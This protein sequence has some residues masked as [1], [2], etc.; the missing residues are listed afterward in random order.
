[1]F[2]LG[3]ASSPDI[4]YNIAYLRSYR[5]S[6]KVFSVRYL[7]LQCLHLAHGCSWDN[8]YGK[9]WNVTSLFLYGYLFVGAPLVEMVTL[10]LLCCLATLDNQVAALSGF[11]FNSCLSSQFCFSMCLIVN[12]VAYWLEFW[13]LVLKV[14]R[15][16]S[17]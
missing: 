3:C 14:F 1:M 12:P 9:R 15:L 10:F 8:F 17:F 6:L 2:V 4:L 7:I 5:F 13:R 11:K 16:D